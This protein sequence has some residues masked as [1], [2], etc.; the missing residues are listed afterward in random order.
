MKKE[1]AELDHFINSKFDDKLSVLIIL[2]NY[3]T[4]KTHSLNYISQS[5]QKLGDSNLKII[6]FEHPFIDFISFLEKI[7]TD[8]PLEEIYTIIKHSIDKRKSQL[9]SLIKE[10]YDEDILDSVMV[11][12]K[13]RHLVLKTMYP[14]MNPDFRTILAQIIALESR[15]IFDLSKQWLIGAPLTPTQLRVLGVSGKITISNSPD[16]ASDYLRIYLSEGKNLVILIDEFEDLGVL[17]T[18][19]TLVNFRHFLDKNLPRLKIVISMTDE[20]FEG[21]NSGRRVFIRKAYPPLHSRLNVSKKIR[22]A[23]LDENKSK[24]F[25]KDYLVAM[26]GNLVQKIRIGKKTLNTIHLRTDGSPRLLSALCQYLISLQTFKGTL[27]TKIANSAMNELDFKMLPEQVTTI[28][29]E[30]PTIKI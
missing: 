25:L 12:E 27:T 8:L 26:D 18:K 19:E 16:I 9:A 4:G 3:G 22:L 10:G 2:G 7:E 14:E 20:A 24:T 23:N 17:G 6:M 11:F 28:E 5:L 21:I 1:K 29:D 15:E 13:S 30:K